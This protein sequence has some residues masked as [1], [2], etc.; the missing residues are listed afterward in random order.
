MITPPLGSASSSRQ[1]K[2]ALIYR[3]ESIVEPLN[4]ATMFSQSRPME[5]ELGSGDGG[6]IVRWAGMHPATNF[7]GVERLLGRIRKIDRK[8]RRALL[9]NLRLLRIEASYFLEYLLPAHSTTA[10]HVYF[11]DPWPKRRHHKN[12][13]INDRFP[14]LAK[15]ALVPGGRVFLRTDSQDYFGQMRSVFAAH[16]EFEPIDTPPE[17]AEI[18]TEFQRDFQVEHIPAQFAAFC[19]TP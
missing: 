10:F 9:S 8:G 5:V 14:L 4:L 15:R 11:P 7:L 19:L 1:F 16:P 17:L 12:R 18:H 13:L 2:D 6:F 3:L